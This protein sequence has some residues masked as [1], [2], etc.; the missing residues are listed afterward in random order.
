MQNLDISE[1]CFKINNIEYYLKLI[2]KKYEDYKNRPSFLAGLAMA[3]SGVYDCSKKIGKVEYT[4]KES[5]K[6]RKGRFENT[7]KDECETSTNCLTIKLMSKPKIKIILKSYCFDNGSGDR[8]IT[9]EQREG[10]REW[11]KLPC[12]EISCE[13]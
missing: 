8:G 13:E 6:V 4:T 2:P 12:K 10:F 7:W 1:R 11:R 3:L 5:S 9:A